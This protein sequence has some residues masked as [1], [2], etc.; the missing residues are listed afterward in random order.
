MERND[1]LDQVQRI[2]R[3]ALFW[4]RRLLV[5]WEQ[6]RDVM[7]IPQ[8]VDG[9]CHIRAR[10][11]RQVSRAAPLKRLSQQAPHEEEQSGDVRHCYF[12][13][14]NWFLNDIHQC[15]DYNSWRKT[16]S[17]EKD[18]ATAPIDKKFPK[19]S[20]RTT[21]ATIAVWSLSKSWNWVASC[22]TIAY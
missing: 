22:A 13:A 4:I 15:V 2:P 1:K 3:R 7:Q 14:R 12:C 10:L 5:R 20:S 21:R 8:S 18:W 16:T 6:H 9:W 11:K 17:F 19:G